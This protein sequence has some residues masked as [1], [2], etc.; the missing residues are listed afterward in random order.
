M[1]NQPLR[2][3][4]DYGEC[5]GPP[6]DQ[7]SYCAAVPRGAYDEV[8]QGVNAALDTLD[9][10]SALHPRLAEQAAPL[11]DSLLDLLRE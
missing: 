3:R 1:K 10:V 11:Y 6:E 4:P 2:H 7:P 5:F 9:V 8:E